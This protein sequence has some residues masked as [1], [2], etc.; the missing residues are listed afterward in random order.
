MKTLKLYTRYFLVKNRLNKRGLVAI[1]CRVTY[2]GKRKD[3]STG[4]FINPNHWDLKKQKLLPSPD[5]QSINL[6][7]DLIKNKIN[8]VF[9]FLQVNEDDFDIFEY[10]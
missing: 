4:I 3:F 2:N 10:V 7:L 6:Q 8:K 1:K 9:L 5:E